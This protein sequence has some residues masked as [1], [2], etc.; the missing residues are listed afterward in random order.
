MSIRVHT[1]RLSVAATLTLTLAVASVARAQSPQAPSVPS[2]PLTL[3]QVLAIAEARSE[4]VGIAQVAVTRTE[5][6]ALRARADER[7]Q[8]SAAASYDRSLA[9]EFQGVFDNIDFGGSD[10]GSTD[11]T[12][13]NGF[14]AT[15]T[16][17]I[18]VE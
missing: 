14:E 5:G 13:D 16:A 4:A 15:E 17:T 18:T 8:L 9:N 1:H 10:N 6:D 12:G 2:G 11:G 3:E 7:P